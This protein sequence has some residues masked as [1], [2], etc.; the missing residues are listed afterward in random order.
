MTTLKPRNS[1]SLRSIRWRFL[2]RSAGRASCV[3]RPGAFVQ[4]VNP[5]GLS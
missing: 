1:T 3:L 2:A 4:L 5:G